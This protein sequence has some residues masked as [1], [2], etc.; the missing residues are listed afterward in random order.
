MIHGERILLPDAEVVL[1]RDVWEPDTAASLCRQL[2]EE[3]A[4]EQHE[5]K[6]F[7]RRVAAPRL[8]AWYGD[9]DVD[10]GYSGLRLT[11]RPWTGP[12]LA[13][14]QAVQALCDHHFNSVLLNRYRDG[15][16]S[17]G[18]HSDDEPELGAEPLIASVSFGAQRVFRLRHRRR[19]DLTHGLALPDASVLLMSGATQRCWQHCVPK[20]RRYC[21]QRLN[22][23][24]RS[25][26]VG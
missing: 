9:S 23:T 13:I 22:L 26:V 1:Y 11:P 17:M 20:T 24:F 15:R 8:S 16:D 10:Y 18:W 21:A 7:G 5:L 14:R 2:L 4:W 12:L 6:L 3:I 25:V 19:R